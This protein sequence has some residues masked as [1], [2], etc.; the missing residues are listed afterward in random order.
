MESSKI[1]NKWPNALRWFVSQNLHSF[2]PWHFFTDPLEYA[3]AAKAFER[4]D[5]SNEKVFVFSGRQDC[6]DF[7]GLEII[8]GK[9]IDR[10]IYFH[11]VFS[12]IPSDRNWNIVNGVFEDVFEFVANQVIPDMKD[13]ALTEDANDL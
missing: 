11:P 5:I 10:V 1:D 7:A 13:W 4:E 6:D 2:T 8:E 12:T 3:F 9:L